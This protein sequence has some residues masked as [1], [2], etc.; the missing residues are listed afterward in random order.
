M[1]AR[2]N[3]HPNATKA[4]LAK[5]PTRRAHAV[6]AALPGPEAGV[7][8]EARMRF[9][10][11][12][13]C[14]ERLRALDTPIPGAYLEDYACPTAEPGGAGEAKARDAAVVERHEALRAEADAL[15]VQNADLVLR[16][17]AQRELQDLE[18]EWSPQGAELPA[19]SD[20]SARIRAAGRARA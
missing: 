6:E 12:A 14:C 8:L 7:A 16:L 18:M 5:P 9:D 1:R 13:E 10:I 20:E 2:E 17:D 15:V 11:W 4:A 3:A 19:A